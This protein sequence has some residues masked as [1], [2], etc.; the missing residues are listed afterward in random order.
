MTVTIT[1]KVTNGD[2]DLSISILAS[3]A[4]NL[5]S[6]IQATY[7]NTSVLLDFV[8]SNSD[9]LFYSV[10]GGANTSISSPTNLS[11]SQGPHTIILYANNS[12][13]INSR[14]V[15]FNVNTS[16]I[17]VLYSEYTGANASSS[18]DFNA[19]LTTFED[20]ENM[21][22]VILEN[23]GYGKIVFEEALN[24]TEGIGHIVD[25]DKYTEISNNSI[26]LDPLGL[27]G[28]NRAATIFIYNLSF[29]NPRVLIDG[30]VCPSNVCTK[31]GYSHGA[32]EFN[33]SSFSPYLVTFS[34]E[35]TPIVTS[36]GGGSGSGGGGSGSGGGGGSD[37]KLENSI[38]NVSRDIINISLGSGDSL[39]EEIIITNK[40][41]ID[42][43]LT[44]EDIDLGDL[45]PEIITNSF[46]LGPLESKKFKFNFSVPF[47]KDPDVYFG[48]IKIKS[49]IG[50]EEILVLI[51][52]ESKDKFF[53]IGLDVLSKNKELYIGQKLVIGVTISDLKGLGETK[54]NI[55]YT[56]QNEEGLI[57]IIQETDEI[58]I[59][60][61]LYFVRKFEIPSNTGLGRYIIKAKIIKG[62]SVQVAS[63]WFTIVEKF[64]FG[65]SS[66]IVK[67]ILVVLLILAFFIVPIII[68][69]E[70]RRKILDFIGL[71]KILERS[72]IVS[73]INSK[74]SV[75]NLSRKNESL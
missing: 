73:R 16:R 72:K 51:N 35:E 49:G 59:D 62:D 28:F 31:Q 10:D 26:F 44:I 9:N 11:L 63:S 6:P 43:N 1:G 22:G 42:I 25:I 12:Y 48:R 24:L 38:F 70:K 67:I 68:D 71:L 32:L 65:K 57:I 14:Q 29:S 39:V 41:A 3:P 56:I 34:A 52:T 55:E 23:I 74:D 58:V 45:F 46:S 64:D 47:D 75:D 19:S 50:E 18:T 53:N 8:E 13:G 69:K 36:G 37:G 15:S 20:S 5:I 54:T 21:Q 17:I 60:K 66:I 2:V 27:P 40:R 33:I 7:L 4:L 61:E 30:S